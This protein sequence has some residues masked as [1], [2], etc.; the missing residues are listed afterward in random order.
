MDTHEGP[1]GRFKVI[2]HLAFGRLIWRWSNDPAT[3]P[4]SIE[5]L[6]A[7]LEPGIALVPTRYTTMRTVQAGREEFVL[8]LPPKHMINNT[9]E[10]LCGPNANREATYAVPP[11]Y[12]LKLRSP[13]GSAPVVS[14][15]NLDNGDFFFSRVAD[16][17]IS[18]CR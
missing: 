14:N 8:R 9:V 5:Q 1:Y 6:R 4:K 10:E 2:D 15:T 12:N 18:V 13:D 7:V 16:Y 17:T 11:F 3:A